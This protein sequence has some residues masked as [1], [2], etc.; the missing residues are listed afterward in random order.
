M[1]LKQKVG[2][3][4]LC[5]HLNVIYIILLKHKLQSFL[6]SAGTDQSNVGVNIID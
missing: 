3:S 2:G 1:T 6:T 5:L 4:L